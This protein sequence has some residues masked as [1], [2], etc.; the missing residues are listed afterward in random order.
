MAKHMLAGF[1]EAAN[2]LMI[3]GLSDKDKVDKR[4]K[5]ERNHSPNPVPSTKDNINEVCHGLNDN[6][7][8]MKNAKPEYLEN[9][10]SSDVESASCDL[11]DFKTTAKSKNNQTSVL[12]R[13]KR[14]VHE[15]NGEKATETADDNLEDISE[16]VIQDKSEDISANDEGENPQNGGGLSCSICSF[17]TTAKSKNNQQSVMGR[18]NRKVHGSEDYTDLLLSD[19]AELKM[20]KEPVEISL[21]EELTEEQTPVNSFEECCNTCGFKSVAKTKGNRSTVLKRHI[22]TVHGSQ[23]IVDT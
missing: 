8:E 15:E 21:E 7:D 20:K 5:G 13:H 3:D 22:A 2:I 12:K 17:V 16:S 1:M 9:D 14:K 19:K 10:M 18:H 4:D 11:C 23:N 6:E